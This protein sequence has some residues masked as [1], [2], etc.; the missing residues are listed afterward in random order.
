MDNSALF[1]VPLLFNAGFTKGFL[2]FE[3]G[4][5]CS[6][7]AA[8]WWVSAG[9]MHWLRRLVL[10]TMWSTA[11]YLIHLYAWAFYG[12]FVLGYEVQRMIGRK[13]PRPLQFLARLARD[14]LQAAP[15]PIM[16]IYAGEI[17]TT[18]EFA[19][20]AFQLPFVR[21]LSVQHLID[22]GD[23]SSTAFSSSSLRSCCAPRF[24]P[25]GGSKCGAIS[26]CRS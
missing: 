7:L 4:A 6:L 9:R 2:N 18:P 25:G 26:P 24:S 12:L 13:E 1:A 5:G 20:R 15:V 17:S 3:L 16:L 14:G 11:L 10:A 21:I 8:A 19:A 23:P 22:V